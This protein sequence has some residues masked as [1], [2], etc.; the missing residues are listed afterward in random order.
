[1]GDLSFGN[2]KTLGERFV[3]T[4]RGCWGRRCISDST[5][6]SLNYG[7]TLVSTALLREE[8][9]RIAGRDKMV[10]I[11]LPPSVASAVVNM[12]VSLSGK[13]SVNLNYIS[14]EE[15]LGNSIQQCG[16][17]CIISSRSFLAK[18]N[19]LKASQGIVFIEDMVESFRWFD[20]LYAYM[21]A[22]FWK[23]EL[24]SDLRG[25]CGGEAATVIFSSGS[26]GKPKGVVLSHHNIISNIESLVSV[27][28]F[29]SDDNLCVVLPFFHSF[30]YTCGLW[31][32]LLNGISASYA[33][34]P[35]DA[36]MVGDVARENRSTILFAAPTFLLRY[37]RRTASSDFV[38][39]RLVVAGAEK[40]RP[41]IA[42][43]FEEKFGIRPLEGYGATEL[44]P[45]VALNLPEYLSRR[46]D[47]TGSKEGTAGKPIPGVEVKVVS[48]GTGEELPAGQ[49]GVLLVRGA[50][51]M[52]G[53]LERDGRIAELI[54][55][56]WYNTGD[57]G[58]I[59][60]G[61]F[62]KIT[63]RLSRFSKIGGEMVPHSGIEEIYFEELQTA[64]QVVA[65]TGIPEEKK[66]EELIVLYKDG[67]VSADKLYEIISRSKLPNIWKPRRNNYIKVDS[68]PKLG[69]GKL[70][71]LGLRKIALSSKAVSR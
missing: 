42:D 44:S 27:I 3:G 14:S 13:I 54:K 61:G 1:V 35:L 53:Y 51:V 50:N 43:S 68:I 31:L 4:A 23:R 70:D 26:S 38:S 66:G 28:R 20:K 10:G 48:F 6:K 49:E 29:E 11:F 37:T 5:G 17:R 15:V 8:I 34:N 41:G 25:R 52:L 16:L 36:G 19:V 55:D 45:V 33:A 57:V 56:G 64:E 47:I 60:R 69:S 39:L 30:G 7:Q 22:R 40:L 32:P 24:L 9:K 59:E 62:L 12:A 71:L 21:K 46:V 63:G 2:G 18:R 58:C 67:A 65:V